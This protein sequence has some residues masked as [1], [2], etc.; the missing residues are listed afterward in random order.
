MA[1]KVGING[2]GRIGRN[3]L[4][5]LYEGKRTGEV[6]IVAL[7][8][9]G[10]AKTNAH[11]TRYDTAHG[12][13]TGEV[14]VDGDY[15]GRERRP[16]PRARRARPGQAAVGR[17]RRRLRARVHRALHQ[18][19]QGRR[20]PQRRRQEGGDLSAGRRGCRCHHRLRRQPPGAEEQ[21]HRHLQRLL[22]HQLP[23]AGGQGAA[24]Q[25]RHRR[26]HHDDHPLL[27]QRPGAD[28]RVSPGPATRALRHHVADPDQ[29]RRRRR[30]GAG[31]AGT[32][33]QA[34]WLLG[35]RADHQRV[36]GRPDVSRPS[37]PPPSRRSTARCR[38][39]AAGAHEGHPRLQR[40][41]A[42]VGGLQPRSRTHR[43]STPRSPR[44]S[45]A[46]WSRCAPGT[47]TSGASPTACSTP[48]SP[49]RRRHEGYCAW[50]TRTCATSGS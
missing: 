38:R 28:R 21:P 5:A 11:L 27:H 35:A 6:Q 50:R 20:A 4:R 15:H 9:L 2:Y 37:A 8:D 17:A 49:G 7:N 23:G 25:D 34:G 40:R 39:R 33:G 42:G 48:R 29:D 44:S 26:R 13:F 3:V 10:D 19:G 46:R 47:T 1:I 18:Q 41:A 36:A 43:S 16:H 14:K 31:D 12:K 24:R 45:A 32:Q 30:G 22:H